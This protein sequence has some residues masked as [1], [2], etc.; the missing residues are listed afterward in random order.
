MAWTRV[1]TAMDMAMGWPE[2]R[3]TGFKRMCTQML[4]QRRRTPSSAM[5]PVPT[6]TGESKK[7]QLL[8]HDVPPPSHGLTVS[9]SH[10]LMVQNVP[11][12]KLLIMDAPSGKIASPGF[13]RSGSVSER[14]C[15]RDSRV[16]ASPGSPVAL[17][18]VEFISRMAEKEGRKFCVSHGHEES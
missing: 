5:M 4:T 16:G 11:M 6:R 9:R 2:K 10:G 14:R 3:M 13:P 15:P 1:K 17:A 8:Q 12:T 7:C 18:M